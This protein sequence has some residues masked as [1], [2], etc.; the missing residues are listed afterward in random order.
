M[1]NFS[2]E[3]YKAIGWYADTNGAVPQL[4]TYPTIYFRVK[5]TGEEISG[6]ISHPVSLYKTFKREE[7]RECARTRNRNR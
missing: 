7:S 3:Q 5:E 2:S 4:S 6:E 1:S